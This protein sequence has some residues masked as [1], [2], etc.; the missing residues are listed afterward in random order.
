MKYSAVAAVLAP[1]FASAQWWA[2]APGCAQSCLSSAYGGNA[3]A[4]SANWPSQTDY[5]DQNNGNNVGACLSNSC[6]ATSTAWSS[7]QALSSSICAQ[8]ASCTSAGSTGVHTITVP[9]GTVTWGAP[10]G[11]PTNGWGGGGTNNGWGPGSHAGAGDHPGGPPGGWGSD[12]GS[13]LWS[14]WASAAQQSGGAHTWTGGVFT[15]TGCVGDGSPWFA[16]PGGGWNNYGGFN[17]WV[18]WGSGW[19]QGPASTATVTYTTTVADN[20]KNDVTVITGMATVAAAVS[21]D[22]TTTQTLGLVAGS[23]SSTANAAA[24]PMRLGGG[25]HEGGIVTSMCGLAL[26]FVVGMALI[27]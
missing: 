9:S 23:A 1:A 3:S 25:G 4:T 12:G 13:S 24:A 14:Q 10:G 11:W 22:V 20:G 17:G 21:G 19:S 6:S 8:W 7:Y 18:G 16:G 5:C 15:V 26:G 2:G 27:L